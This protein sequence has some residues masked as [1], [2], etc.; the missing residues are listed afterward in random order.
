MLDSIKKA[1]VIA[2][3]PDDETLGVGGTILKLKQKNIDVSCLIVSG[4]LPPLY[5]KENFEQT[6]KESKKVFNKYKIKNY[7]FLKIPATKVNEVE[8]YKLNECIKNH[9]DNFKPEIL[10]IPF[11]DRHVDHKCIFESCMVVSRPVGLFYPKMILAYETLSETH[12]NANSIEPDFKPNFFINIDS[13]IE[14]KLKIL[15]LYKSQINSYS[16]SLEPVRSLANFRG[17]QNG[18]KFAEAFQ[19]IRIIA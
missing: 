5:K 1:T 15:S 4:H 2:P 7:E 19:I 9:L 17:S 18:C 13:F 12:W 8:V 3:H 14:K 11:P 16:R 6:Y 10:F